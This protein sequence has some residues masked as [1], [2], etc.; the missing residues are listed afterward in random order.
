M[1]MAVYSLRS[2]NRMLLL[3]RKPLPRLKCYGEK[4]FQYGGSK[5]WNKL[6]TP[7]RKCDTISSFK[8]K[9]KTHLFKRAHDTL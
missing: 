6:P 3:S 7:I 9:L 5:E 8:V 2:S 1:Q 4:C